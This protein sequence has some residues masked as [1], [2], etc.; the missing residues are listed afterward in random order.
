VLRARE[1][2]TGHPGYPVRA[3]LL[4]LAVFVIGGFIVTGSPA[5]WDLPRV[6]RFHYEGYGSPQSS[7]AC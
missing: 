4:A 7:S 3:A 6:E 2:V 5:A 1:S